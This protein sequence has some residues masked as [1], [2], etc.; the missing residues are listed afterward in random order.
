MPQPAAADDLF[1][2]EV[3]QFLAQHLTADLRQASRRNAAIF[4]DRD[5]GQRWMRILAARG[6][7]VPHWP[8]EWGGTGWTPRQHDSFASE[9]AAGQAFKRLTLIEALGGGIVGP[10]QRMAAAPGA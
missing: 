2:A 10:L 5:V 4:A 6:W 7:S 1:R 8:M 3:R 9:P